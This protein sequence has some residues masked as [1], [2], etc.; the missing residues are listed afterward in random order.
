MA[1]LLKSVKALSGPVTFYTSGD[2]HSDNTTKYAKLLLKLKFISGIKPRGTLVYPT[3]FVHTGPQLG[4]NG[5]IRDLVL[6]LKTHNGEKLKIKPETAPS[7]K[8]PRHI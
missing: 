7:C 6:S 3:I 4:F 1:G 2:N 5:V 8:R